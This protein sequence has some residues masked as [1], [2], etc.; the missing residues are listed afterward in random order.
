MEEN[1]RA[2]GRLIVDRLGRRSTWVFL[3]LAVLAVASYLLLAAETADERASAAEI[4]FAGKRRMLSQ[5]IGFLASQA[6][7]QPG[8][9]SAALLRDALLQLET[10]HR[11]L[12]DG[13][14]TNGI[15]S[16]RTMKLKAAY[17]DPGGV[18]ESV[19]KFL[20]LGQAMLATPPDSEA[21]RATANELMRMSQGDFLVALD[22]MVGQYQAE[23]ERGTDTLRRLQT[24]ALLATLLLLVYSARGL[25]RPLITEMRATFDELEASEEALQRASDENRLLLATAGDGIFGVDRDG[26]I[27]FANPAAA[28]MLGR[29]ADLLVGRDHHP[30]LFGGGGSCPICRVTA[31]GKSIPYCDGE[32]ARAGD[33]PFPVEYSVAARP[34]GEGAVISFRDVSDRRKTEMTLQRFQ[35]RLVDAIESMDDAFALFDADDRLALYNL[36]F[37]E[38]FPLS[39]DAVRIGLPFSELV[40]EV[41]RQG[42]YAVPPEGMADWIAERMEAHRRAEGSSE[43]PLSDGRWMRAAERRTREGA[44]VVIWTDVTHLKQALI[45]ADHASQ[46]KSEFLARMSHELRT[47][48]NAILGFAQVLDKATDQ[49]LAAKQQ[50]CVTHI[51]HGGHHLLGL[52]NEVLDLSAIEAGRLEVEVAEVPLAPLLRE[53]LALVSPQAAD[54]EVRIEAGDAGELCLRADRIRLKQVLLNLLSNGIKYNRPG[55]RLTLAIADQGESVRVTVADTGR[56]IAPDLAERVFRPF[57]RLGINQVEGTGIGLAITRRLVELM[58]GR[59]DFT[60]TVGVGTTFC[61]EFAKG[62]AGLSGLGDPVAGGALD[63]VDGAPATSS[64]AANA[65]ATGTALLAV[66][67]SE[68]DTGILRLVTSTLR[69]TTLVCAGDAKEAAQRLASRRFQAMIADESVLPALCAVTDA[70]DPVPP[71]VVLGGSGAPAAGNATDEANMETSRETTMKAGCRWQPKPLKPREMARLL[72]EMLQ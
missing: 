47:P 22:R 35:Q 4:N 54:R 62:A 56:G 70:G 6:L 40:G 65:E 1:R 34:D 45:T 32:F 30:L 33:A 44:T 3:A 9:E 49:P 67:L 72:R 21:F 43:L 28:E 20:Q 2:Q 57:D 64:P 16:P 71:L 13:D 53:C 29:N 14:E 42:L 68:S 48:L 58:G 37:A 38:L 52:I 51:L 66:G 19:H 55:G 60:S 8:P 36:H 63:L 5:R 25:L 12:I 10:T 46:A 17:F 18:D 26:R 50:E 11:Y 27:T 23:S 24:L 7:H 41:A 15:R 61:I 69:E 59:I 31:G 39:G